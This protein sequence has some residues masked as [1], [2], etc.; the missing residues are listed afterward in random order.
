MTY[1][2][3]K[4]F[5]YDIMAK[6]R[7]KP[8]AFIKKVI[9]YYKAHKKEGIKYS[10]AIKKVAQSYKKGGSQ[11]ENENENERNSQDKQDGG[12]SQD[13]Q[14]QQEQEQE[15]QD[16]QDGGRSQ[17]QQKQGGKRKNRKTGKKGKKSAGTRRK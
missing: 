6:T 15:Q 16:Q 7:R 11:D 17:S 4:I 10:D 14:D 1:H 5:L 2:I 9:A 12:N 13:K 8:N 3:D